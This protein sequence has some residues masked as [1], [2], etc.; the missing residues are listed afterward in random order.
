VKASTSVAIVC[1]PA[2]YDGTAQKPCTATVTSPSD[3][4]LSADVTPLS[5][6]GNVEAGT[7]NVTASY[8]G[9]GDH[10]GSTANTTFTIGKASSSITFNCDPVTY[11]GSP[12]T[13]CTATA[14]GAGNLVAA[15]T[16]LEYTDNTD[17][18][19]NTAG[20]SG[21]YAGDA[22][23][24]ASTGSTTFTIG[25][26]SSSITFSCDPVT[27]TGSP[28]T[29]C[30]AQAT[31]AG[32]LEAA[33]TGLQYADNT[34][35]GVNTAGVS[36]SYG[37]D[38]NHTGTTG[39]DTFS[40]G[41]ASSSIAFSCDAVIY[42]GS[43]LTPCSA[44]VSGAGDL[45]ASVSALTYTNNTNAGVNTA[46]VSGSYG[47]DANH[48]GTDG[49]STFTIGKASSSITF[50]CTQ[51]TYSGE[52]LTPCTATASGAGNLVAAV[53][54]L[55]YT[56]NTNA[57]D[58]TAGVSAVYAGD[59]NHDGSSGSTTFSIDKALS[60]IT[61]ACDGVTYDGMSKTPC[62]A[63]VAGANLSQDMTGS[64]VYTGDTINAG[65]AHASVTYAGDGNHIGA[66]KTVDFA[67]GKA[68]SAVTVTC[69]VL[70]YF[71][72]SPVTP[73]TAVATGIGLNQP[74]TAITYTNNT[75]VGSAGAPATYAGD[76]NHDASY[77]SGGFQ[78][79]A[80]TGL[81]FYKPVDM[82]GVV[83][84]VKSGSTVPLKFNVYAGQTE[85]TDLATLNAKFSVKTVSCTTNAL[86]S[87]DLITT[88]GGTSLRYDTTGRQWVQNWQ[89]P[90]GA[91][92]CY[93]VTLSTSDGSQLTAL[94][95]T[96]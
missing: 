47:G 25:K 41:K 69:P 2:T 71:T 18:G 33:V 45:S 79:G 7:A 67:I 21:A 32:G 49:Q 76:K 68:G 60:S 53:P 57:G 52:A 64:L 73:C 22:N 14:S 23:H 58:D 6:D 13:P 42:T 61:I 70:V 82:N 30:T 94:F 89:V 31:G 39:S 10:E 74:I 24:D 77:G 27:Y 43:A 92:K 51:A 84:I 78:I 20:V 81:G 72:G 90:T 62:K 50:T 15:V 17:A 63:S 34:N 96:K 36:G 9:D 85:I 93:Q 26:A 55:T 48:N 1:G 95:K 59:T 80:W 87:D 5:Y 12:L 11:T 37:G 40:I 91:S 56:N 3:L 8:T 54:D 4:S 83:N 35:A 16:G 19:D 28:L 66:D 75:A 46:G 88:T 29:P 86:V 44:L 65:T 38:D